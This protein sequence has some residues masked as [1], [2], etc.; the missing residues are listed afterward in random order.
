LKDYELWFQCG[1]DRADFQRLPFNIQ[2]NR[3]GADL[4]RREDYF[5]MLDEVADQH[6]NLIAFAHP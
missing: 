6:G 3:E 5:Q 4:R 2:R 1:Q